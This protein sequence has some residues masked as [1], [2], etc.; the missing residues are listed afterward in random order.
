MA[1]TRTIAE[2]NC[3]ADQESHT[4]GNTTIPSGLSSIF[5]RLSSSQWANPA[6]AGKRV[7]WG[8]ALSRDGGVTWGPGTCDSPSS[9][10]IGGA[11][12]SVPAWA[13]ETVTVGQVA[14]DGGLPFFAFSLNDLEVAQGA[15]VRLFA[16]PEGA[17]IPLGAVVTG[18]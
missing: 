4:A 13:Y 7:L 1:I 2:R 15:Q 6:L 3:A 16:W 17:A 11:S 9:N 14:K 10:L 5:V 18:N 8:I 12:L